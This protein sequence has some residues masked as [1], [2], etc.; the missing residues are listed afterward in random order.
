MSF[1]THV[2]FELKDLNYDNFHIENVPYILTTF[3]GDV[4]FELHHVVSFNGH[5]GQMQGMD[6][7]HDVHAWCKVKMINIK[8]D[9]D[10]I[11]QKAIAWAICN[12]GMMR[13]IFFSLTN[14][15]TKQL[16][17][18]TLFTTFKEVVLLSIHHFAKFVIVP[19]FVVI[20]L[21][22]TC[23]MSCTSKRI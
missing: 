13:A 19:P 6:R 23:I 10:L 15:D 9:F 18:A 17:L 16:G 2:S 3:N 14:V 7:K 12:V 22:F 1:A 11:F 8:N 21:Q 4:L 5:C 20:Y